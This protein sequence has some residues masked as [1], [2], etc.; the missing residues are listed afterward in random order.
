VF[1][2]GTMVI[3]TRVYVEHPDLALART[4]RTCQ[5]VDVGVV[6]DAGTDPQHDVYTFWVDA[7]DFGAVEATLEEDHTVAS[8]EAI[9]ETEKRRTYQIEYSDEA[10]LI[11]P[12][13]NEVGGLVR[14]TESRS[15]GWELELELDDNESLY[16]LHQRARERDVRLEVLDVLQTEDAG[17]AS[18]FGLT[19]TQTEALV[20]AYVHGFYDEPRE[21]S[22][23]GLAEIL[24]VS[25]T[26]V[27]GRLRRGSARLVEEILIED[28]DDG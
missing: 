8:F 3:T 18:A 13:V 7:P 21:I 9:V 5:G 2:V 23:E 10:L 11:S 4:I 16:R 17:E 6:S 22:L 27:S 24:G 20:A 15:R 1:E 19:E 12:L 26:A 25:P 28:E 14:N